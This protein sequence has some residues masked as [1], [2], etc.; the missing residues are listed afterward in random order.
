MSRSVLIVTPFFAPQNHAAVFR[1]YKLAKYLPQFGWKPVVLTVDTQ[2]EFNEDP[3]LLTELPESVEVV[4]TRYIEPTLRGVRMA[5]G[6][7]SR[8]FEGTKEVRRNHNCVAGAAPV[9]TGHGAYQYLLKNWIHLPDAYWTWARTAIAAG[10]EIIRDRNIDVV[11]TS[12]SPYSCLA[13]GRELQKTGVQWVADFRDPL[14]YSQKLAN[15]APRVYSRQ[16]RLVKDAL[17][18]ADATTI[19]ASSYGSIFRDIFGNGYRDPIFIPTGIDE[20]LV[21]P[22]KQN[23]SRKTPYLIFAGEYLTEFDTSF[24]E[25]FANVTK[26]PEIAA[27]DVKLLVIGTLEINR[28]RLA[29]FIDKFRL[30]QQIEFADQMPQ[31][32][33]YKLLRDACAGVLIPGTR[34]FWW[35][36]FAKMTDYIGMRKPVLAVVPDPSEARTAL[37]RSRLGIF[38]DGSP[39]NRAKILT[40][41][42]L[43]KH[44]LPTPDENECQRYTAHHQVQSFAQLFESLSERGHNHN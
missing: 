7:R 17:D 18:H 14:G 13:V 36:S 35:T 37:T 27:Q 33:V 12:S 23:L 8:T 22:Q 16:R 44:K 15:Y 10:K 6:G 1:A 32:Q 26:H 2:Y 38:L 21:E 25:A 41:F 43:G 28:K 19:L 24:L 42:L 39:E 5:L 3:A 20:A 30:H 31:G 4:R 40:D 9:S 29:P 11:Y 34:A